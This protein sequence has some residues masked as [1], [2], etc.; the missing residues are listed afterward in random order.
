[1]KKILFVAAALLGLVACNKNEPANPT[2]RQVT[3][4]ATVEPGTANGPARIAPNQDDLNAPGVESINFVWEE[5]DRVTVVTDDGSYT[6]DA[7]NINGNQADFTGE[8]AGS[9][10]SYTAY[11]GY[12]PNAASQTIEYVENSFKPCVYG[13]GS[14][15]N[16]TLNQFY[17]VLKLQ[18]KGDV[19]LGKM[20]Y[21]IGTD[22]KATMT[23][24][25]GIALNTTT[26]TVVYLPIA[27]V[28]AAGFSLKFY[29]N[30]ATPALIMK[31]STIYNLAAEMG[32]VVTMPELEVKAPTPEFVD[33]GLR[34]KWATFNIGA[35]APEEYGDY[36][37]WGEVATKSDYSWSTYFDTEDG[38]NTFKKYYRGADGKTSLDPE[39]D[40]AHVNWGG[41]WRMPTTL[42]FEELFNT[43]KCTR[44][45][46]TWNGVNGY[47]ITSKSNGNSIFL[48]EA[49][50]YNG[51]NLIDA[52][53][54]GY[55]W[56]SQISQTSNKALCVQL[57]WT[58]SST[59]AFEHERYFGQPVR[60]VCE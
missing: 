54:L 9:L 37:A 42:E 24:A 15:N 12:V 40:A 56:Y 16:F 38:G 44:T 21:L 27:D 10:T 59:I 57:S 41:N 39:D 51:T 7:I 34:V 33:L 60:A 25:D 26:A 2:P 11:Y 19:T 13:A 47:L 53:T 20:E 18:L 4:H 43:D 35:T 23:F 29:D 3:L 30:D 36:F 14:D 5:G 50:Y 46:E 17:P 49:G 52:G 22:V 48:P 58:Q 8:V 31:K 32:K 6:L 55:Y 45:K 1:M 28:N